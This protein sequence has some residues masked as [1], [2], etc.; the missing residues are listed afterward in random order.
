MTLPAIRYLNTDHVYIHDHITFLKSVQNRF[1][2]TYVTKK[3]VCLPILQ[4][5]LHPL[6]ET[7]KYASVAN[8]LKKLSNPLLLLLQLQCFCEYKIT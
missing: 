7:P 5:A 3:L 6:W 1:L 4:T 8:V 2:L